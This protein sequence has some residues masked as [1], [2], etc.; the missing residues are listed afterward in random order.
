MNFPR[1]EYN[2]WFFKINAVVLR[3][4]VRKMKDIEEYPKPQIIYEAKRFLG[5]TAF[6]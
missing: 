4:L 1:I 5:L 2:F 6:F 3:P